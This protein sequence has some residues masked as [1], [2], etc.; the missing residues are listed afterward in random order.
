MNVE[1]AEKETCKMFGFGLI[2]QS[3][4]LIIRFSGKYYFAHKAGYS[5]SEQLVIE[6]LIS[7][8]NALIAA[9]TVVQEP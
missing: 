3:C 4:K 7:A 2:L 8:A 6:N 1:T 9:I 5:P